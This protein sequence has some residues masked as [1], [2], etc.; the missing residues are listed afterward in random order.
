MEKITLGELL[1]GFFKKCD[2]IGS[3]IGPESI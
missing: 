2:S 3:F 1:S